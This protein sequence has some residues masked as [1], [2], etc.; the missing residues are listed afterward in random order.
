MRS[1][2]MPWERSTA[3][4]VAATG[5]IV[6]WAPGAAVEAA[7][8]VL[9]R[10]ETARRRGGPV[11]WRASYDELAGVTL[12]LLSAAHVARGDESTI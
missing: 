1:S 2:R 6:P 3:A 12:H 5:R 8:D 7:L 9:K 11:S 10:T 4:T